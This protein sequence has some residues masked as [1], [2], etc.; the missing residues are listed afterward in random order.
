MTSPIEEIIKG[1]ENLG[2]YH[3]VGT[4]DV[5]DPPSQE[6][7][8]KYVRK[9]I[10]SLLNGIVESLEAKKK[11]VVIDGSSSELFGAGMSD[12]G[13]NTAIRDATHLIRS[14]YLEI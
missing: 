3:E 7:I 12:N 2:D 9:Q 4:E 1:L 8:A 14:K 5:Y 11:Q 6:E 10:K 13:Y